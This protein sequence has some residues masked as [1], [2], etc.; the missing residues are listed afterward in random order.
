MTSDLTIEILREIRDGISGLR[1]EFIERLDQTNARLDQTNARLDQANARLG[2]VEQ[3]LNDLGKFMRQIAL[4]QAQHERFHT[5]HV[6]ILEEDMKD[7]KT[8]V[9][10]L[11][12]RH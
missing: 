7:L 4:D 9:E 2:N 11:E 6:E 8:R 12:A 5:H 3:G 10:R 1:A